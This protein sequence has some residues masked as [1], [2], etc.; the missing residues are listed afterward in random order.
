MISDG[1]IVKISRGVIAF[2]L[3][4]LPFM[5]LLIPSET[6]AITGVTVGM[7]GWITQ[8]TYAVLLARRLARVGAGLTLPVR[9][10]QIAPAPPGASSAEK[11]LHKARQTVLELLN[12]GEN[13]KVGLPGLL[14]MRPLASI[15]LLLPGEVSLG[16][17]HPRCDSRGNRRRIANFLSQGIDPSPPGSGWISNFRDPHPGR[18]HGNSC[19][20]I[21][22]PV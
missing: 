6:I 20:P 7:I 14:G 21:A 19:L 22:M 2:F 4:L 3:T 13:L 16:R 5:C 12:P 10:V 15:W 17:R 9:Q 8:G 18:A 1:F 11:R